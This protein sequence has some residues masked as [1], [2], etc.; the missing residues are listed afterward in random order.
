[1]SSFKTENKSESENKSEYRSE[2]EK[3]KC[4]QR[5]CFNS[6]TLS[7][8]KSENTVKVIVRVRVKVEMKSDFESKC[9]QR[10]CFNSAT[11]SSCQILIARPKA[12]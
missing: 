12:N 6:A 9:W 7:S 8:F 1:M 3:S 4:W 11:L 10:F 5:F 2:N